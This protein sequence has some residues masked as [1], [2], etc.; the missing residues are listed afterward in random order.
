METWL[1]CHGFY[2]YFFFYIEI[3]PI[4]SNALKV[5]HASAEITQLK[6]EAGNDF[7]FRHSLRPVKFTT[8]HLK[9]KK[10]KSSQI[11]QV[12]PGQSW[13][14]AAACAGLT[15]AVSF[16]IISG[17]LMKLE[18]RSCNSSDCLS[19]V[20]A[21]AWDWCRHVRPP[22][23]LPW[24]CLPSCVL[25]APRQTLILVTGSAL[26]CQPKTISLA[27]ELDLVWDV[28]PGGEGEGVWWQ[29]CF[30]MLFLCVEEG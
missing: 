23:P 8:S 19:D 10:K 29:Q 20:F 1:Q 12:F 16:R 22:P 21:Q 7:R 11:I 4:L 26:N 24:R 3:A 17:G 14:M 28:N 9:K 2:Y 15:F 25:P 18:I 27:G 5:E 13:R 30:V 6:N